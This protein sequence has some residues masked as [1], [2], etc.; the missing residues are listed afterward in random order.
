VIAPLLVGAALFIGCLTVTALAVSAI[1]HV[2]VRALHNG[3]AGG[4]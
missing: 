4:Y 3:F 2:A 1:A